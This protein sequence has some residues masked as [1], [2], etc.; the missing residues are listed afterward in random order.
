VVVVTTNTPCHKILTH[1]NNSLSIAT[2]CLIYQRREQGKVFSS[3]F[4]F[5]QQL[6]NAQNGFFVN[7]SL[8]EVLIV[9]TLIPAKM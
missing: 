7:I 9:I 1:V 5:N 4:P 3:L 2:N 6:F 8:L